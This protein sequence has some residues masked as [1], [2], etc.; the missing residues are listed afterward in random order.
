MLSK[1][2]DHDIHAWTQQT[3]ELLKQR[4]FQDLDIAHVV[5]ELETM[6]RRDRQE[7]VSRLKILLGHLLKWQYQPAHR[8][9]S[10]LGSHLVQRLRIRDLLQDSP[11]LQPYLAEAADRAYGDGAR[12]ASKETGLPLGHFPAKLPYSLDHLLDDDWLPNER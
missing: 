3:A 4:R 2:Y 5:E 11:S 10:W 8:S 1:L 6:G 12:L 9:S 7:L